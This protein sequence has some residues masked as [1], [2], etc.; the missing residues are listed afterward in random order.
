[1]RLRVEGRERLDKGGRYVFISNHQSAL[2]IPVLMACLPCNLSFVAKRSLFMIP[3]LGWGMYAIGHIWIDR[4][5]ARRARESL[6]RAVERMRKNHT[7]LVIFPEGTR[8][9]DG[10]VA[11]FKRGSFSLA[12]RAEVEAVPVAISNACV[13]MPKKAMFCNPGEV[14][15]RIGE[16]VPTK[17]LE[18]QDKGELAQNVR[19]AVVAMVQ[20]SP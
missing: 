5:N 15:V 18:N 20:R 1:V 13:V 19:D 10:T 16:P 8:S 4:R 6:M 9:S 2:D 14:V 12:L 17:G 3:F 7:S 11:D